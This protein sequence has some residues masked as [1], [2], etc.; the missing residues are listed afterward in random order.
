MSNSQMS[1]YTPVFPSMNIPVPHRPTSS[2]SSSSLTAQPNLASKSK[3]TTHLS[4]RHLSLASI[5]AVLHP[6]SPSQRPSQSQILKRVE[7]IRKA[8]DYADGQMCCGKWVHVWRLCKM[9]C[10][11][12]RRYFGLGKKRNLEEMFEDDII[13][14]L[15]ETSE[16]WL[17]WEARVMQRRKRMREDRGGSQ[18]GE[19][20]MVKVPRRDPSVGAHDHLQRVAHVR[21]KVEAW[22]ATVV[23]TPPEEAP[24]LTQEPILKS[25]TQ[26]TK[27]VTVEKTKVK[28]KFDGK[29]KEKETDKEARLRPSPLGFSAVKRSTALTHTKKGVNDKI[30]EGDE[31]PRSRSSPMVVVADVFPSS[32]PPPP[33]SSDPDANPQ[34]KSAEDSISRIPAD[35]LPAKISDLSE[36]E[37]LPPSFPSQLQTSTPQPK[38]KPAPIPINPRHYFSSPPES[39]LPHASKVQSYHS[40][41]KP[42]ALTEGMNKSSS[43][44]VSSGLKVDEV[45]ENGNELQRP[46]TPNSDDVP[47]VSSGQGIYKTPARPMKVNPGAPLLPSGK[48]LTTPPESSTPERSH[49]DVIPAASVPPPLNEKGKEKEKE[50]VRIPTLMELLATAK[51]TRPRPRPRLGPSAKKF[52]ITIE[53]SSSP[54]PS[55]SR[56]AQVPPQ[57]QMI[58]E[59]SP[60]KVDVQKPATS[61]PSPPI[62]SQP[63]TPP[64]NFTQHPSAFLP[65][66]T[67]TQQPASH[68]NPPFTGL[69]NPNSQ[70][71]SQSQ[72]QHSQANRWSAVGGG[73]GSGFFGLSYNSQFDVEG[74]V[75][76]VSNML[77]KDVDFAGWL[78]DMSPEVAEQAEGQMESSQVDMT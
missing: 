70:S 7:D 57:A 18:V 76:K 59:D 72:P 13:D 10:T 4:E 32:K 14:E 73:S 69:S 24:P 22:K 62:P 5:P 15:P 31:P 12:N 60:M 38:S 74:Q 45:R 6:A 29:G 20:E 50:Q 37:F 1:L 9:G 33:T 65:P 19:M 43:Q 11:S 42:V 55:P 78:R 8:L 51:K 71:Q 3:Y 64:F 53:T 36:M 54:L 56:I 35:H 47:F 44:L 2:S 52:K 68:S 48:A 34:H 39:P 23:I 77:E 21:E 30:F 40:P 17:E 49:N 63:A 16:E 58:E 41:T 27:S 46:L 66:V 75:G 26:P 67:S 61:S 28:V 25:Q